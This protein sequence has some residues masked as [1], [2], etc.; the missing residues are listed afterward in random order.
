[1]NNKNNSTKEQKIHINSQN[2]EIIRKNSEVPCLKSI[3]YRE[4]KVPSRVVELKGP[5]ITLNFQKNDALETLKLI[6]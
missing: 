6:K 3:F 4:F 1:M 2:E 5:K